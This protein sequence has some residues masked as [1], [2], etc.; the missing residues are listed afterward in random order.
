MKTTKLKNNCFA[1]FLVL[2]FTQLCLAQKITYQLVDSTVFTFQP[3]NQTYLKAKKLFIAA[4]SVYKT[5]ISSQL[6]LS[7]YTIV[8]NRND[9]DLI[10][11]Y[12]TT[13]GAFD[14]KKS[15]LVP[16]AN[17]KRYVPTGKETSLGNDFDP[18][19]TA[20]QNARSK[21]ANNAANSGRRTTS[22]SYSYTGTTPVY[23]QIELYDSTG[24]RIDQTVIEEELVLEGRSSISQ[25]VAKKDYDLTLEKK[26]NEVIIEHLERG[27][28]VLS[29]KFLFTKIEV[30][31]FV[32]SVKGKAFDDW[33][34][35]VY[36]LDSW[37]NTLGRPLDDPRL[38]L[39]EKIFKAQVVRDF[40][41]F[42]DSASLTSAA[43]HNLAVYQYY[44]GQ[45]TDAGGSLTRAQSNIVYTHRSQRLFHESLILFLFRS[46]SF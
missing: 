46:A 25:E 23:T 6:D 34:N 16:P 15:L 37:I 9:A 8:S 1:L 3:I 35:A 41:Q 39:M 40:T 19:K 28:R 26:K 18:K 4:D 38:P 42:K 20:S 5:V 17:G 29:N 36:A 22:R 33:N 30:P 27:V 21:Y 32:I 24:F 43:F 11:I 44:H 7:H 10:L 2:G 14:G 31:V 13:L 12:N 45:P